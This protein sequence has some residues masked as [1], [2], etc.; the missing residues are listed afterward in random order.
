MSA[1]RDRIYGVEEGHGDQKN[2]VRK[3][4]FWRKRN[5]PLRGGLWRE[6][7][8]YDMQNALSYGAFAMIP[9]WSTEDGETGAPTPLQEM[10]RDRNMVLINE[11][12][13]AAMIVKKAQ[14]FDNS[15]QSSS[16]TTK[17]SPDNENI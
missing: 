10:I 14:E 9:D 12:F 6:D 15:K 11:V 4:R 3:E 2:E 7:N 5:P 16:E 8:G 13:E 1:R 17:L